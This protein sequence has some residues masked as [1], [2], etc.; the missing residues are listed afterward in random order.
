MNEIFKWIKG[1][2]GF[3][4][5]SNLGNVRSTSYKG[6]RILKP[7]KTGN[8]YLNVIL[9]I[10][11]VREHKL[12]HRLVAEA[13]IDNPNNYDTVNH[14]DKN[15]LNNKVENLEWLTSIDNSKYSQKG[16]LIEEQVR[17]IPKLIEEGYTQMDIANLFKTS[18]RTIQWILQG[19]HWNNLGIDFTNLKCKRKI[20]N[21][22]LK[23]SR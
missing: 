14:K 11:Q 9:C 10:N 7:A 16:Q 19:K 23:I 1:Y 8:G 15:K 20:R 17:L 3:Y 22:P 12:I 4:E 13:F 18:R 5:I 21:E 6:T 2:E